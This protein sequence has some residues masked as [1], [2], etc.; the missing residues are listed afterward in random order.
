MDGVP[1]KDLRYFMGGNLLL[2]GSVVTGVAGLNLDAEI[3]KVAVFA[4][5]VALF[6]AA[7][8]LLR[9]IAQRPPSAPHTGL[10]EHS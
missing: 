8:V 2:I 1:V 6:L 5:G 3:L 9:V 7:A 10:D 4:A